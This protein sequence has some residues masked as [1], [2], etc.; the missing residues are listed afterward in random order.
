[1][2]TRQSAEEQRDTIEDLMDSAPVTVIDM[3]GRT[4]TGRLYRV[5]GS[6]AFQHAGDQPQ[7][8]AVVGIRE[9]EY[10]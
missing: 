4:F 10:A 3:A 6:T 1:M 8:D 9:L 5:E 2:S 7:V